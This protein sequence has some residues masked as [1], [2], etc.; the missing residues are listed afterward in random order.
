MYGYSKTKSILYSSK[1]KAFKT[2]EPILKNRLY[3]FFINHGSI[4]K[5]NL[6]EYSPKKY[7]FVQFINKTTVLMN[8]IYDGCLIFYDIKKSQTIKKFPLDH[9]RYVTANN[10]YIIAN[11][12][13]VSVD[14]FDINKMKYIRTDVELNGQISGVREEHKIIDDDVYITLLDPSAIERY[15]IL[16]NISYIIHFNIP[17]N[18][19]GRHAIRVSE[20]EITIAAGT[21]ISFYDLDGVFINSINIGFMITQRYYITLDNVYVID[22]QIRAYNRTI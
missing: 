13:G 21:T 10:K 6:F 20:T 11:D 15:N 12:T 5:K 8:S 18:T 3:E 22:S 14:V 17:T 16:K 4:I 2:L 19:W 9:H 1:C 7:D